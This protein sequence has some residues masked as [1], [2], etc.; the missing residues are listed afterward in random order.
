MA[1]NVNGAIFKSLDLT[2]SWGVNPASGSGRAFGAFINPDTPIALNIGGLSFHGI[3]SNC[4]EVEDDGRAYQVDLVDNRIR[5][6][7]DTVYC[8]FNIVEV[9]EDNP[10]TPGI[11]RTRRYKHVLPKNWQTGV[12]TIT[13]APLT[14]SEILQYLRVAPDVQFG[15]SFGAHANLSAPLLDL[16]ASQGK[17]L[18]NV[19]QEICERCNLIC[20]LDG[21][22]AIRF[23]TKGQ[24]SAPAPSPINSDNRSRGLA[25]GP[26]TKIRIVGD[27][28]LYQVTPINLEPDWNRAY[29]EFWFEGTW[30]SRVKA[31]F[32]TSDPYDAAAKARTVTLREYCAK[33]SK[34][35]ADE[36]LWQDIGRMEMP[37]WSYI[38]Q[39]VYKA[40]RVPLNFKLDGKIPLSSLEIYDGLL[41][42]LKWTTQGEL[43]PDKTKTY[44]DASAFCIAQGQEIDLSDPVLAEAITPEK[45]AA[46]RSLW[47]PLNRFRIDQKNKS[48]VFEKAIFVPGSGQ[49][50]LFVRPNAISDDS[51]NKYELE[52]LVVPNA[53]ASVSPAAISASI[54]FAAERY[55]KWFG[56]GLRQSS[57]YV[58][59]LARHRVG[60]GANSIE[61]PYFNNNKS[62]DDLASDIA[63]AILTEQ[64]HIESGG[65]RRHGTAGTYLNGSISRA[66]ARLQFEDGGEGEGI[67]E[68]IEYSKE[69]NPKHFESERELERRQRAHDLFPGQKELRDEVR[70]IRLIGKIRPTFKSQT[71]AETPS[72]L[73]KA[74]ATSTVFL[75]SDTTYPMGMPVFAKSSED[76]GGFLVVD[77]SGGFAGCLVAAGTPGKKDSPIPVASVGIVPCRVKGPFQRGESVGVTSG[78]DF[79]S[80][81]GT[82]PIGTVQQEYSGNSTIIAKVMLGGSGATSKL[83]PWDSSSLAGVGSPNPTTGL[84]SSYKLKLWPGSV[85][86]VIPGNMLAEITVSG[87]QYLAATCTCAS[88]GVASC[89]L[90]PGG[91]P[92]GP[93]PHALYAPPG[94]LDILIGIFADGKWYNLWGK[95]ITV[96]SVET[97]RETDPGATA[98]G[99]PYRSYYRWEAS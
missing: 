83:V 10:L 38:Q 64:V 52:R 20:T 90:S 97:L 89:T 3:V 61:I 86:G 55:S 27:R 8:S 62:A 87:V 43:S 7:W 41:C 37:V 91:S 6:T 18:A 47:S 50:G 95:N 60:L 63:K 36:R 72:E 45:L 2:R 98:Y 67:S 25:I 32:N 93:Q 82:Y 24:D 81:S 59:G 65:H 9:L 34:S 16:D 80:T 74:K 14:A 29:E 49:S 69:R 92:P 13:A 46:G 88:G 17:T 21:P 23:A 79:A 96:R 48:L 58:T 73:V 11:D 31:L 54:C 4:V 15:W 99:L 44:P 42:D 57:Q 1:I 40:Y 77:K 35:N 78:D 53:G 26:P 5:L 75:D 39:I 68:E 66:T 76:Q 71:S 51:A 85:G 30:V 33:T 84:Y 19:L 56:T 70:R 22:N 12:E 94:N 28:N